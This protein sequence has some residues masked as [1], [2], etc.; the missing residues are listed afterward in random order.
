MG[1]DITINKFFYT[2]WTDSKLE[3]SFEKDGK[4]IPIN[5]DKVES[6]I[7]RGINLNRCWHIYEWFDNNINYD[8]YTVGSY[9]FIERNDLERLLEDIDK[10]LEDVDSFDAPFTK[11]T[12]VETSEFVEELTLAKEEVSK[13]LKET[14]D[15]KDYVDFEFSASW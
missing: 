1:L 2:G 12:N 7:E 11:H 10:T 5:P 9:A 15:Y 14:E 3:I 6:V 13:L 8:G 4:K